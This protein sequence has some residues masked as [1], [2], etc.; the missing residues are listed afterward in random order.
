MNSKNTITVRLLN[1][2]VLQFNVYTCALLYIQ[3]YGGVI[4][5]QNGQLMLDFSA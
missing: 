3:A 5:D 1:A 4:V 2:S